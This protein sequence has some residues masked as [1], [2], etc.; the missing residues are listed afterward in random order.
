LKVGGVQREGNQKFKKSRF[1]SWKAYFSISPFALQRS[2]L[3]LEVAL[4]FKS[5]KMKH[6]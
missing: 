2:F 6:I 1:V 3:E 4:H 5:L